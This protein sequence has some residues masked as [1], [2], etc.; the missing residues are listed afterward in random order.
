[1]GLWFAGDLPVEVV[2]AVDLIARVHCERDAHQALATDDAGEAGGM[3]RLA[4][5]TQDLHSGTQ[6]FKLRP[7]THITR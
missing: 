3:V 6:R 5:R 7:I 2:D 4:R 1:M